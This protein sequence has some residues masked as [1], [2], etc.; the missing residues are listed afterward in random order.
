MKMFDMIKELC[1]R[2]DIS[3]SELADNIGK[4]P[5]DFAE[6]LKQGMVTVNDFKKIANLIGVKFELSFSFL[7]G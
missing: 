1:D 2:M 3:F 5:Q 4:N 7:D 6:D